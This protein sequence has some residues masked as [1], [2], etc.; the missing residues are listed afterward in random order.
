MVCCVSWAVER[1][2]C[3]ALC[4]ENLAIIYRKLPG[5]GFVFVD[6]GIGAKGEQ[7]LDTSDVVGVPV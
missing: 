2:D 1:S 3:C 6:D 4:F 7:I 5:R